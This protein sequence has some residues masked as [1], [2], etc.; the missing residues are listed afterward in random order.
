[1]LVCI[2]LAYSALP[3]F[4]LLSSRFRP[5]WRAITRAKRI[6]LKRV[7]L[8]GDRGVL[9]HVVGKTF[10]LKQITSPSSASLQKNLSTARP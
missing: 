1:M 7:D 3:A 8:R 9:F 5:V 10:L 4:S 6:E 2:G